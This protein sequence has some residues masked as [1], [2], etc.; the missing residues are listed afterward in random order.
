MTTRVRALLLCGGKSSRF[1]SDKLLADLDG[2]PLVAHSARHL[3]AGAGNALAVIPK[4]SRSLMR[5]L[6]DAGCD[7]LESADCARGM[8]ASLA[9]GVR[10]SPDAPGWIV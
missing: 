10:A 1:G 6:D 7:V 5:V 2:Q 9:A 3:L 4:G 8:G